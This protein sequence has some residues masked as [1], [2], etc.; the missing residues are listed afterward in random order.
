MTIDITR[1]LQWNELKEDKSVSNSCRTILN[2]SQHIVQTTA[3]TS[4]DDDEVYE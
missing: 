3:K 1:R 2:T 4:D